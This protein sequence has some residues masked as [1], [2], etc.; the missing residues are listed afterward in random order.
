[1]RDIILIERERRTRSGK[2]ALEALISAQ[3]IPNLRFTCKNDGQCCVELISQL[4]RFSVF[5]CFFRGHVSSV[6]GLRPSQPIESFWHTKGQMVCHQ[7]YN[8]ITKHVRVQTFR[9]MV[10]HAPAGVDLDIAADMHPSGIAVALDLL[11]SA[12][13]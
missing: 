3:Y 5:A 4:V 1:M 6:R 2:Q 10:A 12:C 13:H 11:M 8:E 9:R 7:N